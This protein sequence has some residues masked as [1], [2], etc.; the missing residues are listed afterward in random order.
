[1]NKNLFV[2]PFVFI[3]LLLAS[4]EKI[5]PYHEDGSEITSA[6][7]VEIVRPI[8]KKYADENRPWSVSKNPIPARTTLKYG[9]FGNYDSASDNCGTFKSPSFKAWLIMI[10]SDGMINGPS[11]EAICLFVN[12]LTGEYMEIN[13]GGEV[14]GIEWDHSFYVITE[15]PPISYDSTSSIGLKRSRRLSSSTSGLYA[16][17]ISGGA[18]MENNYS[19]YWNDCQ[20]VYQRLTQTLGYDESHIYCLVA[21]GTDPGIDMCYAYD[22]LTNT[23]YYT[24]SPLDFDNDGDNDIQYS[25]TKASI[26]AVF[27]LLQAQSSSIDHLLVF[28]TDHGSPSGIYLWGENQIMSP[29][30]MDAE[31][32]KLS[33][34]KM[35]IVMGQCYSGAFTA[36][37]EKNRTVSTACSATEPS[38][39][40]G[41]FSYD[42][43]LRSWTDAFSLSNAP[44]VDTNS[45]DMI[46]L[47]EAFLYA[48]SH[49][50]AAIS[51]DE[52]PQYASL[53]LIYGYT[54][55][56]LGADNCPVLS[57]SDY[58]SCNF[59]SNYTIS[60][61]PTST[62][63]TWSSSGDINLTSPTNTSVAAKGVLP[64]TSYVSNLGYIMALFTLEGTQY[65][66]TKEIPSIW[67]PGYYYGYN[68]IYGGGGQYAVET[69][70]GA[71]GYQWGSDNSA[72]VILSPNGS[73]HVTVLEGQTWSPVTLWVTFQDP[74]GNTIVTG[75]QF[76]PTY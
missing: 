30:E 61:L 74:W 3:L 38:Y 25:A 22:P 34:V 28:V 13:V 53:P 18:N 54:H 65:S 66:L 63:V 69:G 43:F 68:H 76:N 1:M 4:C 58:L 44:T 12:V 29:A 67:K 55:D 35:D 6:E 73:P 24:S 72:W 56:L 64:S 21:D 16:V 40:Q 20:Y 7:A 2:A 26:S 14:S 71:S 37:C 51:G 52:H 8:I 57:G 10:R 19:R 39:P 27:N 15:N 60:G 41:R 31:L 23:F 9:P 75:Q 11:Y 17:I 47:R 59:T 36:L 45:D 33:N 46:S 48:E 50:S 42:F 32:D 49:D 70:E 62:S 5:T